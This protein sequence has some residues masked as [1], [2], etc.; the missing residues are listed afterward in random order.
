MIRISLKL[1]TPWIYDECEYYVGHPKMYSGKALYSSSSWK[2]TDI[3]MK[4]KEQLKE[5]IF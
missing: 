3:W 2:L 4:K 5:Y 1:Q